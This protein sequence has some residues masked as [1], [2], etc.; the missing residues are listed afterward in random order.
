MILTPTLTID[1]QVINSRENIYGKVSPFETGF[2][3]CVAMS[4]TGQG[5]HSILLQFIQLRASIAAWITSQRNRDAIRVPDDSAQP[6][7]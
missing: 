6:V 4:T 5:F 3:L 1:I 2:E 7:G